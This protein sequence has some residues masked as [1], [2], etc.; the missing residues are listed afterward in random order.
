MI[1]LYYYLVFIVGF[2]LF[3]VLVVVFWVMFGFY[4]LSDVLVGGVIGVMIVGIVLVW[5]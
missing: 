1:I 5:F 4:Y 2:W 3:V